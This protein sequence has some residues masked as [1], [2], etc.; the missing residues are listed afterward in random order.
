MMENFV[1]Y[2]EKR[3]DDRN[4]RLNA[5]I[6]NILGNLATVLELTDGDETDVAF[7]RDI[8]PMIDKQ[9]C[10]PHEVRRGIQDC[11]SRIVTGSIYGK[12]TVIRRYP[13][14]GYDKPYSSYRTIKT[15]PKEE[16]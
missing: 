10:I 16:F 3:D 9:E 8:L 2:T 4:A 5:A 15:C 14:G 13:Y 6:R 12:D 1:K 7:L 11:L